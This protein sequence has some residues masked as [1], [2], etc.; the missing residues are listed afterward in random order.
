M[1]I[2]S[3][4]GEEMVNSLLV[5]QGNFV[6]CRKFIILTTRGFATC[7]RNYTIPSPPP[8]GITSM[9]QRFFPAEMNSQRWTASP[10]SRHRERS[11]SSSTS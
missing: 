7:G 8:E 9:I 3:G 4:E 2:P 10:I 11:A 1:Q 5:T 6:T